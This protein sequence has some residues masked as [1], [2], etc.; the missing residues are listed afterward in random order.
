[1]TLPDQAERLKSLN[2]KSSYIVQAP[3]G[4]GKTGI[5]VQRIL[6]LLAYATRPES[7]LAITFTRKASEEM[8]HRIQKAL[9][10]KD[11]TNEF[12]HQTYQLA[13]QA[14]KQ[15]PHLSSDQI[16][17]MTFD[18]LCQK[19]SN[20][21]HDSCT[22]HTFPE[23]LYQDA[24][25]HFLNTP[26]PNID[27]SLKILMH[28]L[29]GHHP[30]ILN[31][32]VSL[33]KQRDQWMP[34]MM[35]RSPHQQSQTHA[36]QTLQ[37]EHANIILDQLTNA[38]KDDWV[39]VLHYI[40][41]FRALKGIHALANQLHVKGIDQIDLLIFSAEIFLTQSGT[42]R[43]K[44]DARQGFEAASNHRNIEDKARA[45]AYKEKA[46][47]LIKDISQNPVIK[48]HLNII[49]LLD[50][51]KMHPEHNSIIEALTA[52]LPHLAAYFSMTLKQHQRH[53]FLEANL[54][55]IE[56]LENPETAHQSTLEQ[57]EGIEHILIDEAQDTSLTQYRLLCALTQSW[58][59]CGRTLF[60]VGDPM[61]SIYRFR[62]AQVSLFES[63]KKNAQETGLL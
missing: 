38:Q 49:R 29:D 5:L 12:E 47:N 6:S 44:L 26:P 48:E 36:I 59:N 53:D 32:M 33:L 25:E 61:Q 17:I 50:L 7:I 3:A 43:S 60:I 28:Y 41:P 9:Q 56:Q 18:A 57:A 2:P 13:Q 30:K 31:F 8:H 20:L 10:L 62:Q 58:G 22:L 54:N 34:W 16:H 21:K 40:T 51:S 14:L 42:W 23:H 63:I 55:V 45:T 46:T 27:T 39:D 1:M 19:M 24:A 52:C 35:C 15:H 11:Y 37:A 4:S